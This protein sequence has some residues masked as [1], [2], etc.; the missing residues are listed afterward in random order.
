MNYFFKFKLPIIFLLA[1]VLRIIS[2][3]Y[4]RD[5]EIANEWGIIVE[6]LLNNNI[7]SVHSV[8]GVP[9]P[10]IFMP[11]LYPLFLY[12]IKIF[13][14]NIDIFLWVIQYLQLFFA[15]IAI[16]FANKIL[17]EFFSEKLSAIGTLIFAIFPLNVYA[18]SQISS[19]TLQ[20]LLLNIFI[21]SFLKLFKK[22]ENPQIFL[23]SISSALLMLLRGEFFIFVI[24]SIMYLYLKQKNLTKILLI[25]LITLLIISPYLYRNYNIFGVITITKSGGYNL[26]KGNNPRTKPEGTPMFLSVEKVIP[27]VKSKLDELNAKG[28]SSNYDL[29]QDKILLNQAI[30]FIKSNPLHYVILYFKKVLSFMFI[31][32]NASYA[33]Y[34]SPLHIIPK[35]FLGVTTLIGIILS[36]NLRVN[37]QNFVTLYYFAN[38]GLFSVFFI[39]PRY[40][41]S[42]L[43]IQIILSLFVLKKLRPKL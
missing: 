23:F 1:L 6:N 15:I 10:N 38:I 36:F 18:V 14:N 2:I 27:E 34:Y 9:V 37:A 13:F 42:L 3:Y 32:I 12:S 24:L 17:L 39:L 20:I 28:P 11:P 21:Y 25:S 26:L 4:Y 43:M 8:Q 33:N 30:K 41:L 40:S 7:L 29:A 35:L 16:F 31:D 5:T 22:I 19:I